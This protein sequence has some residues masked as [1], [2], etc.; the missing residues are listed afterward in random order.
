M[1]IKVLKHTVRDN[2]FVVSE[3]IYK[4]LNRKGEPRDLLSTMFNRH[5][6]IVLDEWLDNMTIMVPDRE[7][8][9]TEIDKAVVNIK[10]FAETYLK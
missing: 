2:L 5:S 10:L 7:F 9:D 4:M 6:E 3:D 1:Q 8:F